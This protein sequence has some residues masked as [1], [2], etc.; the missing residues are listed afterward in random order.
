MGSLGAIAFDFRE[1]ERLRLFQFQTLIF[2]KGAELGHVLLL[3]TNRKSHMESPTAQSH[4][5]LGNLVRSN[6]RSLRL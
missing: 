3:G 4:F 1:H 5:N 6:S 2:R